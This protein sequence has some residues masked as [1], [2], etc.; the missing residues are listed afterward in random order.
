MTF[1]GL[2]YT[3]TELDRAAQVRA[4]ARKAMHCWRA[5]SRSGR[6]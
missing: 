3:H 5:T 1:E 2:A 4:E 6:A